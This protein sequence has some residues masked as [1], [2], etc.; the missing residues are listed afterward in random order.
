MDKTI[1]EL[2]A[3]DFETFYDEDCNIRS[4]GNYAYCR[5]PDWEASLVAFYNP[6][7]EYVGPPK[8]APWDKIGP[9]LLAH[10][11]GFETAVLQR[12]IELG[13][14]PNILNDVFFYDTADLAA[15]LGAPRALDGAAKQL[16]GMS[17]D[18]GVR[19]DMKGKRAE[20]ILADEATL[21]YALDDA[22]ACYRLFNEYGKEWPWLEIAL[23]RQ[24]RHCQRQGLGLDKQRLEDGIDQLHN[25][26]HSVCQRIPW[27][28]ETTGK[29]VKKPI[30]IT[31]PKRLNEECQS[32][33]I[34]PPPTTNTKEPAFQKW[35]ERW[36]G[37]ADFVAA[38]QEYRSLNKTVEL[39]KTMQRRTRKDGRLDVGLKYYGAHTG[40]W[41]GQG[42][43]NLQNLPRSPIAG[44]DIR[45]M[46]IPEPGKKFIIAD[47]SQIEPRVLAWRAGDE[48]FLARC[49]DGQSPYEAHARQTMGYDDPEPLKVKNPKLYQL[50]KARVLGL[51][52][53]CGAEKFVD[54]AKA[55]AGLELSQDESQKTVRD[56]RSANQRIVAYWHSLDLKLR[57]H[58]DSSRTPQGTPPY[59]HELPSGR[60][61][62]YFDPASDKIKVEMGRPTHRRV[63]G[64]VLCENDVQAVARDVFATHLLRFESNGWRVAF[65]VHDEVILEVGDE[66]SVADVIG[67]MRRPIAWAPGL[68]VDAEG[69]EVERFQK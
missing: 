66:V 22:V 64:G 51:G 67:E 35:W 1:T 27:A 53:G 62:R 40:R 19:A 8:D 5:H 55:L 14:A 25:E 6:K 36:G 9:G 21:K 23:S 2:T 18:K 3:I 4:L 63:W 10:N 65:H 38:V 29:K 34:D 41:S 69:M 16:L 20:E 52:Y 28:G 33:N 58:V 11:A 32:R 43:L 61:L 37:Q 49:R 24:T 54:V 45:G 42:G 44:V 59:L 68:P 7:L 50:A 39:L 47:L 46:L 60:F 26:I 30:P 12:L 48:D 31:S 17:L 57:R 15:Y 56:Y 13:Q